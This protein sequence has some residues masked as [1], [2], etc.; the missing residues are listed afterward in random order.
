[1]IIL[2]LYNCT[3]S[4]SVTKVK[5]IYLLYVRVR[6]MNNINI[7]R[8]FQISKITKTSTINPQINVVYRKIC[9]NSLYIAKIPSENA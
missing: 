4:I 8:N 1:M 6:V 7:I 5:N 3:G 2:F 9:G